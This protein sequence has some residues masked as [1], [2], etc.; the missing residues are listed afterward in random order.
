[1]LLGIYDK[2]IGQDAIVYLIFHVDFEQIDFVPSGAKRAYK[3][4]F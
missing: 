4:T 1:M 3:V 2:K